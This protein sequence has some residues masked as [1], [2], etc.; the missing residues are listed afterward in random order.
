MPDSGS[1]G[2]N[3]FAKRLAHKAL[4]PIVATAASAVA[5]YVARKG[6]S[7]FE[8]HVLPKLKDVAG[9]VGDVASD[10]PSRAKSAASGAG[11]LAESLTTRARETVSAGG[12]GNRRDG[13]S[14]TELE[15]H[16][17]D[18]AEA[19]EARRK[20]TTRRSR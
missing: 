3:D 12:D 19:R 4:M 10:V 16:L 1:T 13:L 15:R 20:T 8:Q 7:F 18:R 6:P 14:S 11:E 17:K 2:G 9:N 5:G